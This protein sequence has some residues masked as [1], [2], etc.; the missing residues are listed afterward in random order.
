MKHV[1]LFFWLGVLLVGS[2]SYGSWLV[3]REYGHDPS[4]DAQALL[5]SNSE[6]QANWSRTNLPAGSSKPLP[7]FTLTDQNGHDFHG[8]SLRGQV[9]VLSFFF[10]SCPGPCYRLNQALSGLQGD[11]DFKDVKFVSITCDPQDDTPEVLKDYAA[12]F[13]ANPKQWIFLTGDL[14]KILDLGEKRLMLPIAER[15]HSELAVALDKESTVRG[16][17]H[18]TDDD[19]V[20]QIRIR[21]RALLKERATVK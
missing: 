6:S 8:S 15:S 5:G 11:P 1:A 13:A 10:A 3:W 16:Y 14:K 7:D 17:F 9:T 20:T 19:D 12:R 18:L 2:V 4:A 21:L